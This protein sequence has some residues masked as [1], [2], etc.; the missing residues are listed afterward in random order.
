MILHQPRPLPTPLAFRYTKL[1]NRWV[2]PLVVFDC[3]GSWLR[4]C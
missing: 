4:T 2:V 1:K 3:F